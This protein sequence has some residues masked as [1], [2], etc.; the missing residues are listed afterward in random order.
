MTNAAKSI[1]MSGIPKFRSE[2]IPLK[3]I[4]KNKNKRH[5]EDFDQL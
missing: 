1:E 5:H 4:I 3:G 2:G